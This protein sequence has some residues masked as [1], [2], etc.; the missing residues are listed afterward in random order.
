MGALGGLLLVLSVAFLVAPLLVVAVMSFDA[1][2]FL[3]RFPPPEL[4]LRWYEA[5]LLDPYYTRSLV[6][7]LVLAT[8]AAGM[9]TLLGVA[10]AVVIDR[11]RFPGRD[12]LAALFLSP[13]VVPTVLLGFSVLVF[14]SALGVTDGIQRLLAGHLIL[15]LPYTIRT[16]LASLGGIRRSLTEAALVLGANERAA[17]REVTLPLARTGVVAG[18]VLGFALSFEEVSLSLFLYDPGSFTLPVAIVGTMR[19]QFNLTL[20]AASVVIIAVTV[21]LVVLIERLVGLDRAI[22]GGVYRS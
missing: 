14:L 4:S 11:Y 6:N 22:G 18:F 20:A 5:F 21:A 12:A 13:L 7:S 10:G 2:D 16:T 17:F 9:A 1:R 3:G 15:T 19:A 8:A